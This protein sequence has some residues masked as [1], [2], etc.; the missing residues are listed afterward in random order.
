MDYKPE[1]FFGIEIV[2]LYNYD[3]N[4]AYDFVKR[5]TDYLDNISIDEVKEI[6]FSCNKDII[7]L[8][9]NGILLVNEE[10]QFRNI[11]T[12]GFISGLS[13]FAISNDNAITCITRKCLETE[14]INNN[15]YSYKKI[16]ITP[17][18]I[19]ALTYEKEVKLFG[20]LV[21]EVV[22]YNKYIDV[23]DIGYVEEYDNIVVIKNGKVYSLL[24]NHD[25]S[26]EKPDVIVSKEFKTSKSV[27][28][29][30]V[31]NESPIENIVILSRDED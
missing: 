25:Y 30:D 14:F 5:N 9:K 29:D 15:N 28:M 11:K 31:N 22:D 24:A 8:L 18:V 3:V 23:E 10:E 7:I 17:L 2:K 12:L 19:V 4:K 26:N 21:D 6:M 16:I 13:I 20:T 1:E 27:V